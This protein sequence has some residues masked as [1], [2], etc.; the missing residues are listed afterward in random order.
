[1]IKPPPHFAL[2]PPRRFA[3]S[4]KGEA[5]FLEISPPGGE[6]PRNIT[7]RGVNTLADILKGGDI[8]NHI[9]DVVYSNNFVILSSYQCLARL[10]IYLCKTKAFLFFET[11]Y[12]SIGKFYHAFK[13]LQY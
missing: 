10:R 7:P 5:I 12:W 2:P 13:D 3:P 8:P 11:Y 1:M 9:C 6:Y 4:Q